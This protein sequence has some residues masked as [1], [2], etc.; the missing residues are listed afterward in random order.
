MNKLGIVV[1]I[2]IAG[3]SIIAGLTPASAQ[4]RVFEVQDVPVDAVAADAAGARDQA[5]ASGQARAF[6]ILMRKL[7]RKSDWARLPPSKD[8]DYSRL[9]SGFSVADEKRSATR[10][11]AKITYVFAPE[12]V[13]SIL[14][15]AGLPFSESRSKPVLVLPLYKTADG[16]EL[17]W[18]TGNPWAD[19]WRTKGATYAL[20]PMVV[21]NVDANDPSLAAAQLRSPS[22]SQVEPLAVRLGAAGVI[23][24]VLGLRRVGPQV[25]SDVRLFDI[26]PG[27]TS[28]SHLVSVG[29]DEPSAMESAI[30]AIAEA[31]SE[32]WKQSTAVAEGNQSTII[33]DIAYGDLPTWLRIRRLLQ[34]A[35]MV[36]A[37]R[38]VAVSPRDAQLEVT[39]VGS[40]EQL[41]AG[42]SQLDLA[43]QP[44][45]EGHYD[46]QLAAGAPALAT[47]ARA[48]PGD[49]P[50]GSA[51][52]R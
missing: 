41:S 47:P 16:K 26:R 46:I 48:A 40:P 27:K 9:I 7:T 10:Y 43:F 2:M 44:G 31:E 38:T 24:P 28:E 19:A 35:P 50:S 17:L 1:S 15:G 52:T 20:V 25:Q 11:I 49:A 21:P 22:W 8:Q 32:Q 5:V 18:E 42:L 6:E 51:P 14:R 4:S 34:S 37:I 13:R 30:K 29:N 36:R 39:Y 23:M 3:I 12:R 33:A 45:A